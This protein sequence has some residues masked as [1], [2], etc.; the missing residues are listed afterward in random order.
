MKVDEKE[1]FDKLIKSFCFALKD[2]KKH[3]LLSDAELY[4]RDI[5]ESRDE[6]KKC[7]VKILTCMKY[8]NMKSIVEHY[9]VFIDCCTISPYLIE[10][11]S[12]VEQ[13]KKQA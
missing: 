3:M 6:L 12:I 5:C 8:K 2:I 1:L 7:K 10:C 9:D 4:E 13:Y 11:N